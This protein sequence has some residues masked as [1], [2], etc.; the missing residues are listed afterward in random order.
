M[1]R[2]K[3]VETPQHK[4]DR[5]QRDFQ[6]IIR[7]ITRLGTWNEILGQYDAERVDIDP[8]TNRW[9]FELSTDG[10]RSTE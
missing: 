6:A 3:M 9:S 2:P 5:K 7:E 10:C 1:L 4:Q 8:I